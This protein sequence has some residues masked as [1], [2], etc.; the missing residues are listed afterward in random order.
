MSLFS[1]YPR[2]NR[3]P[4]S[5]D[6]AQAP[7]PNPLFGFPQP[8]VRLFLVFLLFLDPLLERSFRIS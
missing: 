8:L 7:H 3:K 1:F 6:R 4:L 5:F 2:S